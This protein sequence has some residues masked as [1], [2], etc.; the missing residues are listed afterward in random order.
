MTETRELNVTRWES[1][2]AQ[3]EEKAVAL[4]D[5]ELKHD[6]LQQ[7]FTRELAAAQ[8]RYE[9]M[10]DR[11]EESLPDKEFAAPLGRISLVDG[12]TRTVTI[13]LGRQDLLPRG[14]SMSVFAGPTD[15]VAGRKP[16][17]KIEVLRLVDDHAAEASIVEDRLSDLILPGDV[18]YTPAWQPGQRRRFALVGRLDLDGDGEGDLDKIRGLVE[19][20]GGTIDAV[21]DEAGKQTGEISSET[22]YLIVGK[23]PA[24]AEAENAATS[25]VSRIL[26]RA[27]ELGVDRMSLEKFLESVGYVRAPR[28]SNFRRGNRGEGRRQR[29]TAATG[30]ARGLAGGAPARRSPLVPPQT[31]GILAV[32][33]PSQTAFLAGR[34]SDFDK[35]PGSPGRVAGSKQDGRRYR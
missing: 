28:R 18:V 8:K 35:P 21:V 16:K 12:R 26:T 19:R 29:Q 1:L 32:R 2:A 33:R 15:N 31:P 3:L 22:R 10:R 24:G 25:A 20:Q 6:R 34:R 5:W 4:A 7:T 11:W 17:G 23:L 30:R 13:D 9:L 14:L 27:K